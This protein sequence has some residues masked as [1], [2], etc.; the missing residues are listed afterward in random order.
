MC[1]NMQIG[2]IVGFASQEGMCRVN[3]QNNCYKYKIERTSNGREEL[4]SIPYSF[5]PHIIKIIYKK[6]KEM[7][8]EGSAVIQWPDIEIDSIS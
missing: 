8:E 4:M 3:L 5:D 6:T 1:L 7:K 2:T